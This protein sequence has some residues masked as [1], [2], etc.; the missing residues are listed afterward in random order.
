DEKKALAIGY[1][2]SERLNDLSTLAESRELSLYYD[3]QA[4]GMSLEYGL[5]ATI[6]SVEELLQNFRNKRMMGEHQIFA[7]LAYAE[8]SGKILFES[9]DREIFG[10]LHLRLPQ[11][12]APNK[13]SAEFFYEKIGK[14]EYIVIS[15]PFRYKGHYTGEM[16]GWIPVDLVYQHF[17][18]TT[19]G[20]NLR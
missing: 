5:G 10:K 6:T 14:D 16:S 8:A 12:H 3:N 4:L 18:K 19:G 2:F 1:F 9:R 17:V 15:F 20:G 11:G 13:N 7:R